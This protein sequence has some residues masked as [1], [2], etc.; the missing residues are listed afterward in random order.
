MLVAR[1]RTECLNQ[2]INVYLV[3]NTGWPTGREPYGHGVPIVVVGVTTYQGERESRS[4]G[5]GEQVNQISRVAEDRCDTN[6]S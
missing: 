6:G 1:L 5:E 4:Q 2:P 3:R